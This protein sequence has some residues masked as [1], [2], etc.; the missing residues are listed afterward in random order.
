MA[1]GA[2]TVYVSRHGFA[3]SPGFHLVPFRALTAERT[4][5]ALSAARAR[6]GS[7]SSQGGVRPT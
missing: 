5:L 3:A 2:C 6:W 1:A 4:R 7:C